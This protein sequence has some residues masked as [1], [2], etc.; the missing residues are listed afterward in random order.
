MGQIV[1]LD[2]NVTNIM[3]EVSMVRN[4]D[5]FDECAEVT[6]GQYMKDRAFY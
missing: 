2:V 4:T 1:S 6:R 3:T 5:C